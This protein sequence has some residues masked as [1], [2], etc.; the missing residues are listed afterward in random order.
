MQGN[1]AHVFPHTT[2]VIPLFFDMSLICLTHL[3]SGAQVQGNFK[4]LE[5]ANLQY[6]PWK[7]SGQEYR[8]D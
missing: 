1:K 5:E 6:P 3:D 8:I 2:K 7:R 4:L